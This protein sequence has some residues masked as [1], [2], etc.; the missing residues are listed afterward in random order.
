[1]SD[2]E[3]RTIADALW[4][5]IRDKYL[6]KYLAN[7]VSYYQAEVTQSPNG[8]FVEIQKPF[9]DPII[10]PCAHNASSLQ[11]GDPCTVLVFGDVSNQLVIGN[12][13]KL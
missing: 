2:E 9:D 1:M 6:K 11:P 5:Y 4:K 13:A 10:L 3:M 8:G 7:S 12:P